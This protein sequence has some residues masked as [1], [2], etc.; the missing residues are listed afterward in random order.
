MN[1][2]TDKVNEKIKS[3]CEATAQCVYVDPNPDIDTM[4]GHYC[5]PGVDETWDS[6]KGGV[7][8]DR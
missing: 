6:S 3:A 7:S 4:N 5:E 8:Q 1:D 2:L